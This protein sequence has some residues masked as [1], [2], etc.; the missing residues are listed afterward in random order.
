M[1]MEQGQPAYL[2]AD[3]TGQ[4]NQVSI[5]KTYSFPGGPLITSTYGEVS[6][7]FLGQNIAKVIFLGLNKTKTMFMIFFDTKHRYT[8]FS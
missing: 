5:F 1:G 7:I 8:D 6:P 2:S 3:P 4:Q